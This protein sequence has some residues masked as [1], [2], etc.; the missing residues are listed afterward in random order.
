MRNK[1]KREQYVSHVWS[2][3]QF[4]YA[5]ISFKDIINGLRDPLNQ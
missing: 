5:D 4:D 1:I 3:Y 2:G